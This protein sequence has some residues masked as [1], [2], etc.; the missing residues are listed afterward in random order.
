MNLVDGSIIV[1]IVVFIAFIS[2]FMCIALFS[3]LENI[4]F[5]KRNKIERDLIDEY[6][7]MDREESYREF[8]NRKTKENN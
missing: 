6:L 3:L 1:C 2:I 8:Y 4:I 5:M 7:R